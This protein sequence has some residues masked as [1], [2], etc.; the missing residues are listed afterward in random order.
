MY[1]VPCG[2]SHT[3]IARPQ[4]EAMRAKMTSGTMLRS[5]LASR[6]S[7]EHLL[8]ATDLT[9][10]SDR[11]MLRAIEI[12][13]A[14]QAQ[15]TVVHVIEPGLPSR[16]V[17]RRKVEA[18]SVIR[19]Q[20]A[21]IAGGDMC[22][23]SINVRVGE[24]FLEVLREAIELGS[25]AIVVGSGSTGGHMADSEPM[26]ASLLKYCGRPVL[27][28]NR[29]STES[30][31]RGVLDVDLAANAV[32]GFYTLRQ[33]APAAEAHFVHVFEPSPRAQLDSS[34]QI[35]AR[36]TRLRRL[37]LLLGFDTKRGNGHLED[38]LSSSIT[39]TSGAAVDALLDAARVHRA[40]L[41]AIGV[42]NL[43]ATSN[44]CLVGGIRKFISKAPCDVLIDARPQPFSN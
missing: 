6:E 2:T 20:V 31:R 11:A 37:R 15:V 44:T 42:S 41:A 5:R 30:Y 21:L 32:S 40:D 25:D 14:R 9:D 33:I 7:L 22:D 36:A 28:V 34:S 38:P 18:R 1:L 19:Q 17:T 27:V 10:Q 39:I 4:S 23:V 43:F 24:P 35:E 29:P 13:Q 26:A 8:V 16:I 12:G 3:K